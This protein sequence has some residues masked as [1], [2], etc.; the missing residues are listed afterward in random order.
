LSFHAPW[1]QR[2]HLPHKL[3]APTSINPR[4]KWLIHP[5]PLHCWIRSFNGSSRRHHHL[6]K[7][8]TF[9]GR[10][11]FWT[12]KKKKG[13]FLIMAQIIYNLN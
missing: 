1:H 9:V 8:S 10:G 4:S 12:Y 7:V 6:H 13:K 5:L 3:G 2:R 11:K